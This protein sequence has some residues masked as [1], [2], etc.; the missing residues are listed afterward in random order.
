M[1]ASFGLDLGVA[2]AFVLI[3]VSRNF[4]SPKVGQLYGEP[5]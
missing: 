3:P 5:T 2:R 1:I 4:G